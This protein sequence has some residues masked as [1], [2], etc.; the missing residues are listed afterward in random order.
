MFLPFMAAWAPGASHNLPPTL[1]ACRVQN[2]GVPQQGAKRRCATAS[3]FSLSL[4]HQWAAACGVSALRGLP[5]GLRP[6]A[7]PVPDR[8]TDGQN[9]TQ[10]DGHP[11]ARAP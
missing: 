11:V 5:C 9:G 3:L 2:D 6:A 8:Q 7:A 4:P 1:A 10:I